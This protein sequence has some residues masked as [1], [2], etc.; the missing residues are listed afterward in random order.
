MLRIETERTV[1][2]PLDVVT[3]HGAEGGELV[4]LDG[5]GR[6]YMRMPAEDAADF[7]ATGALGHHTVQHVDS[8]GRQ[9]GAARFTV[10]CETEIRDRGG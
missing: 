5:R 10:D 6:E 3:I 8:D 1:V 4:V 2:R 7:R 9:L